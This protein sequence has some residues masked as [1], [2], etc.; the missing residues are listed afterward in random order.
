MIGRRLYYW[1]I[2]YWLWRLHNRNAP[3][4]QYY[5]DVI[6]RKLERHGDHPAIGSKA[7]SIRA[8]TELLD[9]MRRHGMQPHHRFVDYGCGSLRLGKAVVEY[10]DPKKF[11]GMDVT[12][13]FLDLGQDYLG[14]DI[15]NE[16]Q[17]SLAVIAPESLAEAKANQPDFIA[18]WHV[19]S[20]VPDGEIDRYFTSILSI[21]APT[22]QAFIQ[23]PQMRQRKRMNSLNWSFSRDE[24]RTII[25][26]LAPGVNIDFIEFVEENGAGVTE[27]YAHLSYQPL[28]GANGPH[29]QDRV[30]AQ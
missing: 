24:F 29:E 16:K 3:Y 30:A 25:Q 10:L 1:H 15:W 11:H 18:S 4:E 23:F 6:G 2:R 12:Q 28:P 8:S 7:R 22:T 9:L 14:A 21:M 20:K 19:C 27:T 26:R 13:Q 17:P 5:A